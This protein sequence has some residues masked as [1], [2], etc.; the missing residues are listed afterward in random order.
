MK[1]RILLASLATATA[2]AFALPALAA[3]SA[4]DFVDKAAAGGMFEVDSSKLAESKVQDKS[5]KDFA[6]KMIDDHGT[7]N[8]KLETIAGEQK[9][10]VPKELDAKHKGD[11]DTLQN[12]KDPIDGPYVQMQRDAHADAVK[13]FESYAKDGDNVEL[14][15]FAQQTVPTLKMHQEM[16]EKIAATMGTQSSS[17]QTPKVTVGDKPEQAPPLPGANSFTEDQAKG[18]IQDAG[19]ADVSKLTKDDQ[20]IWRGQANK[21]GKNTTVALDYKGNVVAGTN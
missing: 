13:L 10:T 4:Q 11:V 12:G 15:T 16:I 14:K 3:D 20:G 21:D 7:A 5:V 6:R 19:F 9:L 8:A 17:S 2:M 1:T 18:R